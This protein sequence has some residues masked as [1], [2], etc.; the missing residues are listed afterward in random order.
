MAKAPG[1]DLVRLNTHHCGVTKT[2]LIAPRRYN[3]NPVL[4]DIEGVHHQARPCQALTIN[5]ITI[6]LKIR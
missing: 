3:E 1:V 2:A 4:S 5:K 6:E